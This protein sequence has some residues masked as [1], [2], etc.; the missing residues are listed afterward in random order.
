MQTEVLKEKL[1][2]NENLSNATVI[3][4]AA[5]SGERF[6]GNKLL[7][8]VCD[9][10]VI[11]HTLKAFEKS[12]VNNVVIA[13]K[14]EDVLLYERL[15][16][17]YNI[18]KVSDIVVGGS[19]RAETVKNALNKVKTENVL[20]HDGARPLVKPSLI[21]KIIDEL[22]KHKAVIPVLPVTNT[23][24]KVDK[25]GFVLG[26]TDRQGL[27][28]VQ[29]PQGYKTNEYKKLIN[30]PVNE[31]ITDDSML[32]ENNGIPVATVMGDRTNIKITVK[33]DIELMKLFLNKGEK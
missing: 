24:K 25:N 1:S 31:N 18:K 26:T 13:V 19:C 27:C 11:V 3:I 32:F 30:L 2:Y 16:N 17:E 9:A 20:I 5:G 23:V 22:N 29:T 15:V 28:L 7:T 10:P 4:A 21:N 14:K 33:E 6:G 8:V 12:N